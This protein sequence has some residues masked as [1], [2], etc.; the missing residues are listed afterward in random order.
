M[1]GFVWQLVEDG[2]QNILKFWMWSSLQSLY[3]DFPDLMLCIKSGSL[4]LSELTFRFQIF[5]LRFV[6][7]HYLLLVDLL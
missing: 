1:M 7:I 5:L 2:K 4:R 3:L 6:V